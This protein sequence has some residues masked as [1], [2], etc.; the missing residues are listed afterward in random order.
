[1]NRKC[2]FVILT[3]SAAIGM[4]IFN[5]SGKAYLFQTLGA[6]YALTMHWAFNRG[7]S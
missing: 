5:V 7:K 4:M 3:A 6:G 1:M 2:V